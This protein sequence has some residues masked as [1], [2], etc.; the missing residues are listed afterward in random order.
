[1]TKEIIINSSTNQTRVAITEDGNLVDF[2]VDYPENR[3]MV[4]DI[5]LGRVA[6]VLPGIKAAF[7]DIGMKHDAFLHFSDI[8][9][10]TKQFQ[11][12][13]GEEDADL[14]EE[15]EVQENGSSG[16]T[17]PANEHKE[18]PAVPKLHKGQEIIVQ[19]TKEPVNNKGVRVSSSVSLPGRFC[20]LLPFDGKIGVSKKIFDF[21]ER[22]RLRNIARSILPKNY[23]LIIRTV[24]R[25][26]TEDALQED[27]NNLI[28]TWEEIEE[29]IKSEKPP[30]LIYQDLNTTSSVIRDLFSSD[31]SKVFI[32]SK[33]LYK[34]IK[35]YVNVV[36]PA[37]ADKIELFKSNHSI[38]DSFKIEEQIK[39]LMGRKVPLPSG[40][41]IIIE[42]T[43]A[44]V[45]I[46]VN[47]GRYAKSKEQ[48]LNSL[49]T[50]L[51][52]AREIARQLRLRDIGGIIVVDFIDLEEEKNRKKIYDELRKEFRK[53]RAKVSVLPMSDFGLVQ[54]TRQRIRQNIMQALKEVCPYCL[55]TGL[56]TKQS[57]LVYDLEDWIKK[58]KRYSR[59]KSLIVKCHPTV[60]VKLK[61]GKIKP[62]TKLQL[63]YFIRIILIE[64]ESVPIGQFR[65]FSKKSNKEL[66]EEMF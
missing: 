23:G 54:I 8:G 11:E 33:K 5:Y 2:F 41:Y 56:L 34:Q 44:M 38:F 22:R 4:G 26:Q 47:S 51:E 65:F 24:A 27:L 14:E 9:E 37:L 62:L 59:E 15:D 40:G 50:D 64:D 30:A 35:N 10:T 45:V 42:H 20:V 29:T 32:D 3:R 60:A 7:I 1:M 53:D 61:E 63:K 17:K 28:K 43:E 6:R 31:V 19:I 12:M 66:T 25:N 49:R 46:D 58:F 52:A 39:T 36:H 57:H 48:E 55:G 13:L 18:K 16:D 21:R